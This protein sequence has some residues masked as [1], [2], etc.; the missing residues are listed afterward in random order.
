LVADALAGQDDYHALAAYLSS[1]AALAYE[2]PMFSRPRIFDEGGR[3]FSSFEK[4]NISAF[5]YTHE[6]RLRL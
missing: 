2:K 3:N 6:K 1:R 4:G 5:G